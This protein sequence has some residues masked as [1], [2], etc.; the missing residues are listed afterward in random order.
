MIKIESLKDYINVL[1]KE[2]YEKLAISIYMISDFIC[3]DYPKYK[4]WYFGKQL[5]A[6]SSES[7]NILFVRNPEKHDEILS[8]ACFKKMKKKEKFVLYMYQNNG[9]V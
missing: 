1:P 3:E 2:E 6:I 4:S 8:M 7:R 9:K 5:P